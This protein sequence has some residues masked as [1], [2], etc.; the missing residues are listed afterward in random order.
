[1]GL[2]A[3][4]AMP[5]PSDHAE[6]SMRERFHGLPL[7]SIPG[8]ASAARGGTHRGVITR[9]RRMSTILSTYEMSTGHCS[10]HARHVMHAR[11]RLGARPRSQI[12]RLVLRRDLGALA[13]VRERLRRRRRLA[14][15]GRRRR[16]VGRRAPSRPGPTS[17]LAHELALVRVE[18]IAQ[19][20]RQVL[21]REE[22]AVLWAG[23]LS[24]QRRTRC[25]C[26]SRGSP[27]TT[28]ARPWRRRSSPSSLVISAAAPACS[29][30]C[31]AE[32]IGETPLRAEVLEEDVRDRVMSG[33]ASSAAGG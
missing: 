9:L 21:G 24:E 15:L 29:M 8:T 2:S 28:G 23:Q 14:A 3:N 17:S 31:S 26:R 32:P 33:S 20:E 25:T 18:V 6:R 19:R 10:S 13:L 7:T 1:V 5:R 4:V 12:D 27:S 11:A 30:I 16:G 22:L